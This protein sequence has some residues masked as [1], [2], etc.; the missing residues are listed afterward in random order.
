MTVTATTRVLNLAVAN[1]ICDGVVK[2]CQANGFAPMT[3]VVLD[4]EG[5]QI[6]SQ[7]MDGCCPVGFPD[8]AFAKATT[9]VVT[10]GS[11]RTFRDKHTST[12]SPADYCKVCIQGN[13]KDL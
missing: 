12:N 7:R 1:K 10:K 5:H 9:C 11:S 13:Q 6:A 2:A 8:F 3:V 4:A